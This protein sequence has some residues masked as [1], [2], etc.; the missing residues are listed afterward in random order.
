M[1]P[2]KSS[3][4][5][6]PINSA[7]PLPMPAV[8][9]ALGMAMAFYSYPFMASTSSGQFILLGIIFL[10]LLIVSFLNVLRLLPGEDV[11][12]FIS[13]MSILAAALTVGFILGIAAR[14]TVKNSIEMGLPMERVNSVS[15]IL[16]EDP[17]SL[18]GG[19]GFGV[20]ELTMAGAEGGLRATAKGKLTVFFPSESIPRLKEFGRGCEIYSDGTL[21]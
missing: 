4:V 20:L 11:P 10:L 7:K 15:G 8:I 19:S 5:Q 9:A 14:Q 21:P 17:R 2:V 18:Q 3:S 13:V 12:V 16:I 6:V 1:S